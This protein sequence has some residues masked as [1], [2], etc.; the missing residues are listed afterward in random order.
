[1]LTCILLMGLV[2][3][4]ILAHFRILL[5]MRL[6]N[7]AGIIGE[8]IS[9]IISKLVFL[10]LFKMFFIWQDAIGSWLCTS[11]L[12]LIFQNSET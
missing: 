2:L 11:T 4:V 6:I 12:Y 5:F 9:L 10:T 8:G 7:R 3:I 1:M